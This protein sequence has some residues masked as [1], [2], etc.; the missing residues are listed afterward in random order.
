MMGEPLYWIYYEN[1]FVGCIFYVYHE[2]SSNEYKFIND[3]DELREWLKN[4]KDNFKISDDFKVDLSDNRHE[5]YDLVLRIIKEQ[6]K[7]AF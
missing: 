6:Y 4:N 7:R 5:D 2:Y 1:Q 3:S